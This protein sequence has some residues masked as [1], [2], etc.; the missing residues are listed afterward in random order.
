MGLLKIEPQSE[1]T[2][3]LK[4]MFKDLEE[5]AEKTD[6]DDESLIELT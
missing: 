2:I 6:F 4:K 5:Q 1:S 3:R